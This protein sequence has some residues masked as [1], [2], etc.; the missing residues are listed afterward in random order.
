ML[1]SDVYEQEII[2]VCKSVARIR[3]NLLVFFSCKAWERTVI[4]LAFSAFFLELF[5]NPK[6]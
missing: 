2:M 6:V 3:R 5:R 4:V 1:H